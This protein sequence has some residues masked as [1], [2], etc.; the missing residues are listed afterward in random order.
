MADTPSPERP[1][2]PVLKGVFFI[3]G[4][5]T[6]VGKTCQNQPFMKIKNTLK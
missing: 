4:T 2:L 6:E 5:D 3:T 1:P